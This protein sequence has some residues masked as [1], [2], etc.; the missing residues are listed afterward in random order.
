M[1]IVLHQESSVVLGFSTL[2]V[3][4]AYNVGSEMVLWS[5]EILVMTLGLNMLNTTQLVTLYCK[6]KDWIF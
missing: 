5:V 3:I 1:K 2:G 6:E 4:I